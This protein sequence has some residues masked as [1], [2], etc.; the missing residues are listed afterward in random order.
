MIYGEFSIRTHLLD[1]LTSWFLDLL[2]FCYSVLHS[3]LAVPCGDPTSDSVL[4]L[5]HH[6]SECKICSSSIAISCLSSLLSLTTLNPPLIHFSDELIH[7]PSL[8]KWP[9]FSPF[10]NLNSIVNLFCIYYPLIAPLCFCPTLLVKPQ[11]SLNPSFSL[12]HAKR[13]WGNSHFGD[14]SHFKCSMFLVLPNGL[15]LPS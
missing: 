1:V 11:P 9:H 4:P 12:L 13:G 5:S 7:D 10:P 2:S 15:A 6:L 8:S 3:I 14:R